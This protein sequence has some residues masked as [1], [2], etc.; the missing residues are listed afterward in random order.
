MQMEVNHQ[1]D[2]II[3]MPHLKRIDASVATEFKSK[4][5]EL[6]NR[7]NEKL[8]ITYGLK[9]SGLEQWVEMLRQFGEQQETDQ[10]PKSTT[11][12]STFEHDRNKRGPTKEWLSADHQGVIYCA[13]PPLQQHAKNGT[14]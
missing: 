13:H 8:V 6:I 11:Q 7:G 4:L 3:I 5:I 10:S 14:R 2:V 1:S 12:D 9:S